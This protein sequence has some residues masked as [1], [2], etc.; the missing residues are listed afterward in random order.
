MT[1]V[2]H[3]VERERSWATAVDDLLVGRNRRFGSGRPGDSTGKNRAPHLV[4]TIE[5]EIIPRLMLAHRAASSGEPT[6][7]GGR[8][9]RPDDA[10]EVAR[11]SVAHDL[12]TARS[13]VD[14]LRIHGVSLESVLLD[15]LAPA[16]RLLGD[17]WMRDRCRF[18]DVTVGLCHLQ[19]LARELGPDLEREGSSPGLG[20]LVALVPAPGEQ[21]VFGLTLLEHFIRRAGWNVWTAGTCCLP[22]LVR[23]V[24]NDW[25]AMVGFT[26]SNDDLLDRLKAVITELRAASRNPELAVLVGG[27]CACGGHDLTERLGADATPGGLHEALTYMES[28][29]KPVAGARSR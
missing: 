7:L 20:P 1:G 12:S 15:V 18:T 5:G 14:A 4:R 29:L 27:A 9:A 26:V 10:A 25:L 19:Q 24:R 8:A 3:L 17:L 23:L 16:A 13:Y 22:D 6:P 2:R 21:H 28:H 11:L